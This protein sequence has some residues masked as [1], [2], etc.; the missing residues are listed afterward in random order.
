MIGVSLSKLCEETGLPKTTL[1]RMLNDAGVRKRRV[2]R[3]MLYNP[4]D[5]MDTLGF[6]QDPK[7]G[8]SQLI[9]SED[10]AW[11]SAFLSR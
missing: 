11:L 1:R 10:A 3:T 5:V 7:D 4:A 6:D 9:D 2:G 8:P